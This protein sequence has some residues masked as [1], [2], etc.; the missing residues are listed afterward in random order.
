MVEP[1]ARALGNSRARI[2]L[3]DA[4]SV[5]YASCL[6]AERKDDNG[7]Y[8]QTL[9]LEECFRDTAKRLEKLVDDTDADDAII[10]LSIG[11][12]FRYDILASYKANRHDLRKPPLLN[13]LKDLL[14]ERRKPFGVLA[15]A[16][17]E[18]DDIC[19]ISS[20]AL[21]R[22]NL[23]EPLIVSIDKDMR[24]VPGLSYSWMREDEGIVECSPAEADRAHLIQTLMG[25]V[26]DGYH[27]CPG[28]G[29]AKAAK[30]IDREI[31]DGSHEWSLVGADLW[32]AVLEAFKAKGLTANDA[33]TQARL[34]YILRDTNW[35]SAKREIQLWQ[36]SAK[37]KPQY[38]K[39]HPNVPEGAS[40]H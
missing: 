30:I 2:A 29:K 14:I 13:D 9:T 3:I 34:A 20:T 35:N 7:D 18:A 22:A 24:T 17:L 28:I 27:G 25:D 36:P 8:I 15:I 1:Y 6:A 12:S 10:C 23:R 33:L 26:V 40:I 37:A 4:D 32:F 5:L 11:R 38:V 39:L 16:G 19:G 31:D 21:Q